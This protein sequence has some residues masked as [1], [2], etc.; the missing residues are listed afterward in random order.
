[1]TTEQIRVIE[2]RKKAARKLLG[3]RSGKLDFEGK[4]VNA[5]ITKKGK[6]ALRV[7][8]KRHV[9]CPLNL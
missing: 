6:I 9:L 2:D 7:D 5:S 3:G 8:G 1:M 4:K